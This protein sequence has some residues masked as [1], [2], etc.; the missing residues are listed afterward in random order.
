ML[1]VTYNDSKGPKA[2]S[3]PKKLFAVCDFEAH[4]CVGDPISSDSD[5]INRENSVQHHIVSQERKSR[6]CQ[7]QVSRGG[8]E[9]ILEPQSMTCEKA[10]ESEH[11][12]RLP[13]YESCSEKTLETGC[14][15]RKDH[16][17]ATS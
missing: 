10:E 17:K 9:N 2:C 6:T 13:G 5:M 4:P 7:F 14:F 15:W 11:H 1:L 3:V 12:R 8:H 16:K